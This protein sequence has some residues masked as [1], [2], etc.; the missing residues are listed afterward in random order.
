MH[1]TYV[2][3]FVAVLGVFT[4]GTLC[5][6]LLKGMTGGRHGHLDA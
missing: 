6:Y 1:I 5:Y 3:T 4:I 2:E